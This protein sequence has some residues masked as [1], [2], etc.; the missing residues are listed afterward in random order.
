MN[1]MITKI[2]ERKKE[3]NDLCMEL[4]WVYRGYFTSLYDYLSRRQFLATVEQFADR[5]I[6]YDEELQE[7]EQMLYKEFLV[8]S[9][10]FL[11]KYCR[12]A[13]MILLS[14]YKIS[15]VVE[16]S[17]QNNVPY[18]ESIYYYMF[19][20]YEN[21]DDSGRDFAMLKSAMSSFAEMFDDGSV[22]KKDFPDHIVL[23]LDCLLFETGQSF[24]LDK[25]F[26]SGVDCLKNQIGAAKHHLQR[27]LRED[28]NNEF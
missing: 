20:P 9:I 10:I 7:K 18:K 13:D 16:Q 23:M 8:S 17:W 5:L 27:S 24:L 19:E 25:N 28:S 22:D 11:K 6:S 12:S 1:E 26:S 14:I 3:I 2:N 15:L 21:D 4:R